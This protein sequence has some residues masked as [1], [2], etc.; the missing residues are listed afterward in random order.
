MPRKESYRHTLPHFQQLGQ[1]YFITWNLK[2]A[3]PKKALNRY[4]KELELLKLKINSFC[5][6]VADSDPRLKNVTDRNL[7]LP[8]KDADRNPHHQEKTADRNPPHPK[9]TELKKEHYFLRKKY[10]K[11]YDDLLDAERNPTLNLAK[12]ENTEIII[13]ALLFWKGEKLKTHALCVMPNHVH[14]VVELFET[15]KETKPVYLEEIMYSVK[16]FTANEINK[17][18]NRTGALWQKE[19]FD[20]TIREEKHLYHAI[21][22]TLNNPVKAG[23]IKDWHDWKGCRYFE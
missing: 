7:K 23:L 19:S 16:R 12:P 10:I 2:D 15:E 17:V 3:V 18:E 4:T 1:S 21:E 20:T 13:E 5:K 9:L 22:Y 11:A 14:W 8:T 6:G